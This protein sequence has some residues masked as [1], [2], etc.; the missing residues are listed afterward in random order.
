MRPILRPLKDLVLKV[1]ARWEDRQITTALS[2]M[3]KLTLPEELAPYVAKVSLCISARRPQFT[4]IS[5]ADN[6]SL[7]FCSPYQE[8]DIQR[9]FLRCLS[10]QGVEITLAAN[11][12]SEE[13]D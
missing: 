3:G 11:N 6:F 10:A 2:N 1:S 5:Y 8:T 13:R 12:L 7:S 4:C 9:H